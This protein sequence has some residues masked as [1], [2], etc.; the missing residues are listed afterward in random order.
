MTTGENSTTMKGPMP[1]G[2]TT[3][4]AC[5]W[6]GIRGP[7]LF[8]V[9][10][11]SAGSAPVNSG[12]A[13]ATAHSVMD[14]FRKSLIYSNCLYLCVCFVFVRFGVQLILSDDYGKCGIALLP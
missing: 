12:S 1:R 13:A 5:A 3:C 10:I 4:V 14:S 11:P 7:R 8:R 6:C 2:Y 9:A